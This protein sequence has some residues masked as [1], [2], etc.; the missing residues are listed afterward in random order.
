[1]QR[2]YYIKGGR[3]WFEAPD[4]KR[5]DFLPGKLY[6]HPFNLTDTF[7]HDPADPLDHLYFDFTS[8]PPIISPVPLCFDVPEGSP[9]QLQLAAVEG[10]L[11][12]CT[13]LPAHSHSEPGTDHVTHRRIMTEFLELLILLLGTEHPLPFTND[14]AVIDT[15]ERIRLDYASPLTVSGLAAQAGFELN[16]FIRRF[17]SVMGVTPYAYLRSWRLLKAREL[18]AGGCTVVRAAE[19]VGY[20]NASS[21][22][23]ALHSLPRGDI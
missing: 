1:M 4:G 8:T 9:L 18:L 2:L 17:R 14:H 20:E 3:G 11:A 22:S 19:L 13:G 10:Y 6:L 12:A 23:R 16:Y 7:G 21:L 5:T 15:L